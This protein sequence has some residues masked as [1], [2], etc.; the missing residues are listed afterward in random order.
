[1]PDL[2]TGTI[3]FLFTDI[4]GSTR[5]LQRLGDRY[6]EVVDE[7]GRIL[8]DAIASGGGTEIHT[9]GDSFFAVFRTLAGAFAAVV[10]AQRALAA[11]PWPEGH[12]VRVRMGLH[13]G[14][15]VLGGDDYIG[16]DV[17]LAARIAAAGHGGQVLVSEASRALVEHTLPDGASLRD[18]GRH[19]LKDIEHPEHLY[20]LIID[21]LPA[22]FPAVRTVDARPTNLPPQRS[23]FVGRDREVAEVTSLLAERRLLTLTG[24]GGT[25][26]TRLALKVAADHLDRFSDGVFFADLSPIVDSALVPSVIAQALLVREEAG[27]DLL[28]TLA[29][30]L[31]DRHLL[32]VLD[33]SEQVIEAGDAVARLVDV[34]PRLTVL[35][36]S[37]APFN[38]SAEH[39]YHVPPL[40]VP[41]PGHVSDVDAVTRSEAVALFTERAAAIRPGFQ[42]TSQNAPAVAE[43]AA[44]L[45][46][47]PL[48]IELAAS[49]LK[50]LSPHALLKRLDQRLSLLTGGARDLPERQRTLRGT[51]EWSHDL[52]EPEVQ[53]LFARLGTFNGGWNLESA[54]VICRQDLHLEVLDG[55][56]TLIDHSMVRHGEPGDVEPRFTM[57]D[58]I[59]EFAIE[60]L[61]SSGEEDDLRRRHAEHFRDLAEEAEHHLTREDR[62]VWLS[63]LEGEHDNLRAALDRAERTRDA[64]DGLRT[65]NAIW[66]FWLQRGHLSEG[67]GRL[68]RLLSMPGAEARGP[69]RARALG[70][71][72][73]IAY[74]QNDYPP[75]RAAYK[76]AA[77]IAREV[78]DA[79]LL[80]SALLDLSFIPSLEK[81]PDRTETILREGLATAEEAGDRV[82]TAEFWSNIAFLEVERGN[83]ADA[84]DLRRTAIEILREEG[85]AWKL[86]QYLGGLAMITRMV[87]DLDAARGHLH[88]ALEMFAQ[89]RDT[90]SI[91]MT[92]TML[93][94]IANDDGHH[95]R[96]ARLVGAAARIRDELGGG[97]PPEFAGRW[98]DP[99][100][101]AQRGLGE[102]TYRRARAE[103]Y[104]MDSE[105]AVAYALEG[106]E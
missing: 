100:E 76:E 74:W 2:P 34:A 15:G 43:I 33:N 85:A 102:D 55:L 1:M 16:L 71:L 68:E 26:K 51:I 67:R 36:T 105:K 7:H 35:A 12:S 37:R 73:G 24:P 28:D 87:G 59:R 23:S 47:L 79:K 3:T 95:E 86:G 18:L 66:R 19:R 62:V 98:G 78:G 9:E 65:A 80:A 92:L 70:A 64:D 96:A 101:E 58:T 14:K 20:D 77:D 97:V 81:D 56:G 88:E 63:R 75:M 91:S 99:E 46:G 53:R 94:L 69:V 90:M 5:L 44:R 104:A 106:G 29:D 48:A 83:P 10:Q 8:R 89:A 93:A 103:G 13:T 84:I 40:A 54:E 72:G 50:V 52:L 82:L 31:R 49:R 6:R 4:E 22:E 45:D 42:I 21:G 60:R 25:G 57:L 17:H 11:H 30:H 32:L 27:R 38:V 41:D 61:A 39:E